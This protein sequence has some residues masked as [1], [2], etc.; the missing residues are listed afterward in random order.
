MRDVL[1]LSKML[2]KILIPALIVVRL[3]TV[4]GFS[5]YL[6]MFLSPVMTLTGLPSSM[7]I[8]WATTLL[9][10]VPAGM[11][12]FFQIAATESI[13]VAQTSVLGLMMLIG[14][15]LPTETRI[16]QMVGVRGGFT[17]ALRIGG[18]I[19]A[20]ALL[21]QVYLAGNWLQ[22]PVVLSGSFAVVEETWLGWMQAQISS[23]SY[24]LVVM[25]GLLLGMKLLKA[26]GIEAIMVKALAP[27]M[28]RLGICRSASSIT[29]VGLLLGI[30]YGGG[31]LIKEANSGNVGK[32]DIILAMILLNLCHSIIEDSLLIMVMG[33]DLSAVLGARIVF[34]VISVKA[35]SFLL[36]RIDNKTTEKY[37]GTM[38]T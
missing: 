25:S 38:A 26:V 8:V 32:K 30:T 34:T 33:A 31:L 29:I 2:L 37:I 3:L 24:L 28:S 6:G 1:S 35:F 9:A 11:A 18:A 17:V 19:I 13:T 36:G 10:S 20:G 5:D 21:N 22:E 12:V 7:G 15:A 16:P 14:H 4:F 27:L 23:L